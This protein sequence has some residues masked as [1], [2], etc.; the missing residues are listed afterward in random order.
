[1]LLH[2]LR[3]IHHQSQCKAPLANS[4]NNSSTTQCCQLDKLASNLKT[5]QQAEWKLV[6]VAQFAAQLINDS[7]QHSRCDNTA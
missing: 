6:G 2:A 5:R 3:G 1:M 4:C 7:M